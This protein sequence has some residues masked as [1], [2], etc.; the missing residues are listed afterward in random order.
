MRVTT[1]LTIAACVIALGGATQAYNY[2]TTQRSQVITILPDHQAN[3]SVNNRPALPVIVTQT[4]ADVAASARQ[5][6]YGWFPSASDMYMKHPKVG[7]ITEP[8]HRRV[9]TRIITRTI[10]IQ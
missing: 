7:T 3:T 5:R 10:T 6:V 9:V 4:A 8:S 1:F 2:Y